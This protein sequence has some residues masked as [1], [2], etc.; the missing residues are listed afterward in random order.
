LNVNP[1]QPSTKKSKH[2]HHNENKDNQL[3]QKDDT[4]APTSPVN[5]N[6]INNNNNNND[7]NDDSKRKRHAY[8]EKEDISMLKFVL[9]TNPFIDK[10]EWENVILHFNKEMNINVTVRSVRDRVSKLVADWKKK[11]ENNKVAAAWLT[12]PIEGIPRLIINAVMP[13]VNPLMITTRP[14]RR[15]V[16]IFLCLIFLLN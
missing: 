15:C 14:S 4:A 12:P 6:N 2:H 5:D 7:D 11:M 16:V 10:N 13:A 8:T 3:Q 9:A 1:I